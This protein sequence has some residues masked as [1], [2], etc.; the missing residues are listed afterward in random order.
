MVGVT[1]GWLAPPDWVVGLV[2]GTLYLGLLAVGIA[3]VRLLRR[4]PSWS[5][6]DALSEE[7]DLGDAGAAKTVM[8]ASTSR[9]IAFLGMTAILALFLGF[10]AFVLWGVAETGHM[11]LDSD[12]FSKYLL[13][14]VT[15]F[16]PYVVNKFA[17]AFSI[18]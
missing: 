16:A 8:T 5:L 4:A 1:S 11:P 7:A 3:V 18:R 10:G 2:I 9:L 15:L 6:A 12:G 17:A 13:G 14:G